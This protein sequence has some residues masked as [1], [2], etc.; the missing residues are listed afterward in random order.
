MNY[1]RLFGDNN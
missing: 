1:Q